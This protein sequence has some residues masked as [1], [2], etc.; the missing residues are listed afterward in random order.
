L[1]AGLQ[2]QFVFVALGADGELW[3]CTVG[4]S[5]V[6]GQCGGDRVELLFEL[7]EQQGLMAQMKK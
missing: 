4:A 2:D 1:V 3:T 5:R 7:H 6:G